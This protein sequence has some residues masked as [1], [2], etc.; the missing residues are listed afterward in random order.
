[1]FG[2]IFY[3]VKYSCLFHVDSFGRAD[4]NAGL[5]IHAHVFIDLR[6]FVLYCDCRCGTFLDAGLASGAFIGINDCNQL[7]HSIL[8]V[9]QKIKNRFL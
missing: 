4:V 6:L 7:F 2:K 9:K 3:P 5:A 8:Y 1:M